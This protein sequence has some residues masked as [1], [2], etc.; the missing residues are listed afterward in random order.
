MAF[1]GRLITVIFALNTQIT[2]SG[3]PVRCATLRHARRSS[4]QLYFSSLHHLDICNNFQVKTPSLPR[5]ARRPLIRY[6]TRQF[7]PTS[8]SVARHGHKERS[9]APLIRLEKG[10]FVKSQSHVSL[11]STFLPVPRATSYQELVGT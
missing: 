4:G 11:T 10:V 9:I 6:V 8:G 3:N 7:V 2:E 5:R 1:A